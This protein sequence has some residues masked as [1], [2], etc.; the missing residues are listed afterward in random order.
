MT[1]LIKKCEPLNNNTDQLINI[2]I[3][4]NENVEKMLYRISQ[5]E[6]NDISSFAAK[7][8]EEYIDSYL[9]NYKTSGSGS[10]RSTTMIDI[11]RYYP[12]KKC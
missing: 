6:Q 7:V 12:G 4:L 2:T 1:K 5:R 8:I 9:S 10:I 3:K 11:S